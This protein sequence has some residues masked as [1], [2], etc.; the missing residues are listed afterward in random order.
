VW[1]LQRAP[2]LPTVLRENELAVECS[3]LRGR[4]RLL[5]ARGA[6]HRGSKY[7]QREGHA[8]HGRA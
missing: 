2:H 8:C 7:K 6:G 3:P 5:A 1:P 4:E